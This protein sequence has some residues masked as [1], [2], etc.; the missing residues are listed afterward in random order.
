MQ[1]AVGVGV[2]AIPLAAFPGEVFEARL[3]PSLCSSELSV[4]RTSV[5]RVSCIGREL[6]AIWWGL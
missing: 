6:A 3:H 4:C 1:L 2:A 5:T